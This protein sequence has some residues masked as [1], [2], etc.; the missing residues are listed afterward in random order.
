MP[1]SFNVFRRYFNGRPSIYPVA[2]SISEVLNSPNYEAVQTAP[3]KRPWWSSFGRSLNYVQR[4]ILGPF[5]N[6]STLLLLGWAHSGSNLKSNP[7]VNRLVHDV[8]RDP[9]FDPNDLAKFDGTRE[10]S[11]LDHFAD[12]EIDPKDFLFGTK[13]GW[14]EGAVT[15]SMPCEGRKHASEND[16]KT[17]DIPGVYYRRPLEIM[18]AALSDSSAETYHWIPFHEYWQPSE[19]APPERI[20]TELYNSDKFIEEHQQLISTAP[21][22]SQLERVIMA[23]MIWSDS[24]HLAKFGDASLWPIYMYFGNQSKYIHSKVNTFSANHLAYIP[25]VSPTFLSALPGVDSW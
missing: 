17:M 23:I 11:R 25:K 18:K 12:S 19:T 9:G 4:N 21:I 16:A 15:M 3:E 10:S 14:V 5:K 24:T 2:P 22:E 8:L 7:E 6:A 1:N 13:D 20:Y